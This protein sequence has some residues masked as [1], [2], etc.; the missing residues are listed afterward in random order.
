[1]PGLLPT[2]ATARPGAVSALATATS[3]SFLLI[4]NVSSFHFDSR[5]AE[6]RHPLSPLNR[7]VAILP[8]ESFNLNKNC[9]FFRLKSPMLLRF[10]NRRAIHYIKSICYE[11][12]RELAS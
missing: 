8:I 2:C 5:A 3:I 4:E 11:Y 1:M 10:R 7:A 9:E 6:Q 12:A